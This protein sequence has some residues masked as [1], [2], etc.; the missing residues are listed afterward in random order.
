MNEKSS[1]INVEIRFNLAFCRRKIVNKIQQGYAKETC[2]HGLYLRNIYVSKCIDLKLFID[3][4]REDSL[5][6]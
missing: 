3:G 6:S 1:D 2:N 5:K 4:E